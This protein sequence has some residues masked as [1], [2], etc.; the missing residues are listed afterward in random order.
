MPEMTAYVPG[1]PCWVDVSSDDVEATAVFYTGLFGWDAMVMP[2][3]DGYT[4]FLQDGKAVAAAGGNQSGGPAT[5]N[6]YIA[7]SDADAT[8][9]KI[10][11]AG[12]NVA[13]EPFDVLDA[14]RMTF[15]S[16][17]QGTLF[18]VWQ[19]K[20]SIGAQLVNEP[21]AFA[22]AELRTTDIISTQSFYTEVFGWIPEAVGDDPGFVYRMQK[23][24][25]RAVAGIFEMEEM[26]P[27]WGVYFAVE[28]TDATVA[29]AEELGGMIVRPAEDTS[30]GRMAVLADPAGAGFAVI[31]LDP[32]T[33]G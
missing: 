25:D 11:A 13:L 16:D 14:G 8:A 26:P 9:A 22:W 12:G 31:R 23:L 28:D 7:T 32:A 2:D 21:V 33:T 1:T 4:M 18:G 17:T 29:R 15:A 30:Y 3:A 5:W 27:G 6:T 24:E 10:T 19:G 20:K